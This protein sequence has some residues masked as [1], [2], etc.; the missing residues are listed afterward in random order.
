MVEPGRGC[1]KNSVSFQWPADRGTLGSG[2]GG[3][4]TG[5]WAGGRWRH[6][7]DSS[8]PRLPISRSP[9]LIRN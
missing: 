7:S 9:E 4:G 6:T 3:N 2:T 1:W 8:V 5:Q